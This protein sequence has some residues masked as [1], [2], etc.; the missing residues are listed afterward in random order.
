LPRLSE[1]VWNSFTEEE[2]GALV[3]AI[4]EGVLV[5]GPLLKKVDL[6]PVARHYKVDLHA[7]ARRQMDLEDERDH[8]NSCELGAQDELT[9]REHDE[10]REAVFSGLAAA[11]LLA[12]GVLVMLWF[13]AWVPRAL[14]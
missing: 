7:L 2:R 1:A 13:W 12:V 4:G 5:P 14:G 9:E 3:R 11:A 6:H 10:L 8:Q